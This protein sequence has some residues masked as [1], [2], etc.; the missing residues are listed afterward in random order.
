MEP[1]ITYLLSNQV[2]EW[3]DIHHVNIANYLSSRFVLIGARMQEAYTHGGRPAWL[4]LELN[5]FK[6]WAKRP[7]Y[8]S[9]SFMHVWEETLTNNTISKHYSMYFQTANVGHGGGCFFYSGILLSYLMDLLSL[10]LV[11]GVGARNYVRAHF[12]SGYSAS[13]GPEPIFCRSPAKPFSPWAIYLSHHTEFY[14][15]SQHSTAS[16]TSVC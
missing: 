12:H 1:P 5:I 3:P 8:P 6:F 14:H 13:V 16:Q 10:R 9:I 15:C 11:G 4:R 7:G 2:A